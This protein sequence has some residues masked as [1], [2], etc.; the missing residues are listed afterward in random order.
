MIR[1]IEPGGE[2]VGAIHAV[3]GY[4][5]LLPGDVKKGSL[6]PCKRQMKP[7]FPGGRR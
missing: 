5:P 3:M 6:Y 7:A 2:Q 1:R 4:R